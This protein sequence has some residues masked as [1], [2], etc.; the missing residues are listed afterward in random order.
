VNH[1]QR[2]K[3]W[4]TRPGEIHDHCAALPPGVMV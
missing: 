4:I 1:T 2:E 3:V